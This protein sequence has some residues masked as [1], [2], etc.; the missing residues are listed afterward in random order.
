M[1]LSKKAT[2]VKGSSTLQITAKTKAMKLSGIDIVSFTAGEPDFK[3][4]HNI[5]KAAIDAINAGFTKYT[6]SAGILK[7]REAICEKLEKDNG[8]FYA[9]NQIVVSNGAKHAIFNALSVLLNPSDEVI[10]FAPYWLSYPEMIKMADGVPVIVQTTEEN[11]YIPTAEQIKNAIT[12]KTK[13][14]II[15]SPCNPSGA[16]YSI[17]DLQMI[18]KLAVEH[19]LYVISDEIY[20]KLIYDKDAFHISIAHLSEE[21]TSRTIIVNGVSKAFSMTGWRIG[22]TASNRK[23]AACIDNIQSHLTS[24]PNSIAQVAALEGIKNSKEYVEAMRQEFSKRR[25]YMYDRLSKMPLVKAFRPVGAFYTFVDISDL[26]G[27]TLN[28]V[29]IND[30]LGF[31]DVLLTKSN[32][33]VVPC[34][35]FGAPNHIRLSFCLSMESIERGLDRLEALLK[36]NSLFIL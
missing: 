1:V 21:M 19:D 5:N 28:G 30:A 24:S 31:T 3:T 13:I 34:A 22:Y 35:D 6:E 9:P 23:I 4:P 16:V 36:G 18:E 15:N 2:D 33:A 25:D 10:I 27:K 7:L 26:C 12:N 11:K 8:L 29:E 17:E 32:V 14:M 20:E